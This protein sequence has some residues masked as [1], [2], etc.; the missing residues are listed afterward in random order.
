ME[1][2]ATEI[3]DYEKSINKFLSFLENR[4][5]AVMVLAT[6]AN[7]VV[8][9][10]PVLI[11]NDNWDIYFFTWKHSRKCAQIER[12]NMISLC[13]DKVE[14]EGTAEILGLITSDENKEVFRLFKQKCPDA[15]KTWENKPNMVFVK[16]EPL[17]ARVDSYFIN[18]NAYIE[19]VDFIKQ[20]AFM[21]KWA[22]Y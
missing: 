9:A 22:I 3:V 19:Y 11:I 16:V 8:M 10:R 15:I 2:M 12:N 6:S 5:N 7:N 13:K 14:I 21:E 20:N 18:D 1:N 4:D 17:L